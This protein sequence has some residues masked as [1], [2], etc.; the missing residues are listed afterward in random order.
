MVLI[1]QLT[2]ERTRERWQA[3][4]AAVDALPRRRPR[5]ADAARVQPRPRRRRTLVAERRRAL[6]RAPRWRRCGWLPVGLGARAGRDARRRARRRDRRRAPGRRRPRAAGRPH[7]AAARARAVPAA[8]PRSAPQFHASADGLAVGR[9]HARRCSTRRRTVA[10]AARRRRASPATRRSAWRAS[11]SRY[12]ARPG[13]VLDDARPRA[14][15][16]RDR[17]AGRARAAP[18]R[19]RSP[20]CCS[21]C[22]RRP[23][24][25]SPSAASTSPT[26]DRTPGGGRSPGCRSARRCSAARSPRTSASAIPRP[27]TRA[28]AT[29]RPAGRRRRVRRARCRDGYDTVI[30]DGGRRAVGRASSGASRWRA[31]CCAT[32]RWWSSTS[33]P[34]TSTRSS[35]AVVARGGRAGWRRAARARDRRTGPSSSPTPTACVRPRAR[36]PSPPTPGGGGRMIAHP[37]RLLA[38]RPRAPAAARAGVALGALAVL[39]G[40]GLMATAGYLISRARRAA[41]RSCRS[42]SPSSRVRFFGLGAAARPLRRA[43]GVPRPRAARARAR[44][45]ARV[46]APRAAR[47]RRAGAAPATA[48]CSPGWSATSTRC[49]TCY[50]RGLAPPL[51]AVLAGA[52]CV[53]AAAAVLLPAAGVVLARRAAA[54]AG[55]A[56][57]AARR[58][59]RPAR[60]AR[61]RPPRARELTAELVEL[62]GGAPELVVLRRRRRRAARG[63]ARPTR[64]LVRLGRRDALAGGL[65]DGLGLLVARRDGRRRARRRACDA[66]GAGRPRPRPRRAAGAARRWP[67]FEAVAPLPAAARELPATLAAGR[68]VLELIDRRARGRRTRRRP[69]PAPAGAAVVVALEGVRAR[70]APASAGPCDGVDLRLEPGRRVALVGPSG[71]GKTT[72]AEPAAALPRPGG[73]AA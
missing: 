59:A 54:S 8:A 36:R 2:E 69:P 25:A 60:G 38:A 17:R 51:V 57:P 65:G 29:P 32:R 70:Y 61:A 45:R 5:P 21:D 20:R 35:A 55:V 43:A 71:A 11:R 28:C 31:R 40:V 18:A 53:G 72:V 44:V 22:W 26:A 3:L 10:A 30:G 64:E 9:A 68:R 41:R 19:A 27:T 62:L 50:L 58:R 7:R 52:A 6:P 56:V 33:P 46:S 63:C 16:R 14:A 34:P 13:A 24:G 4:R 42:R 66:H 1:G 47:A 15:P 49:R 37:R 48:T 67:S 39:F 73:G 23:P 12:P